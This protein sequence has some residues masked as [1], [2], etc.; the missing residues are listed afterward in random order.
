MSSKDNI[1]DKSGDEV[2]ASAPVVE[3]AAVVAASTKKTGTG[4]KKRQQAG[5][6]TKKK[7]KRHIS[8]VIIYI[9]ASFNN[10]IVTVTDTKGNTLSW[11]TAGGCG[12]RGSRKSTPFAGQ[13]ATTKAL[14]AAKDLYGIQNAQVRVSGPGPSR[15]AALRAIKD[16]VFV[17]VIRDV[18]PIPFNGARAPKER[19]V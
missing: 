3:A 18:T 4:K 2:S 11:A 8:D 16:F 17:S 7:V 19:R 15:D 10:T 6:K 5:A 13:V 12:Y 14:Q 9:T 1:E